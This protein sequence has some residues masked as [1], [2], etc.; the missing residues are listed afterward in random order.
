LSRVRLLEGWQGGWNGSDMG[1]YAYFIWPVVS[2][3]PWFGR[4]RAPKSS[5]HDKQDDGKSCMPQESS[6]TDRY[7]GR[8]H[9]HQFTGL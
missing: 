4:L 7:R 1:S 9:M 5:S 8:P 6:G 2:Y 3:I